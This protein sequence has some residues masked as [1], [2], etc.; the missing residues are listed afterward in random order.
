MIGDILL[1]FKKPF[2]QRLQLVTPRAIETTA[3]N[4]YEGWQESIDK[5]DPRV[6]GLRVLQP[7]EVHFLLCN[8]RENLNFFFGPNLIA[9]GDVTYAGS[10]EKQGVES[11]KIIFSYPHGL[12]YTRYFDAETGELL[13]TI[14]GENGFE[15]VEAESTRVGAIK[16]PKVV[17]TYKDDILQRSVVFD[18]IIVN[19][20]F[21][22]TMFDFPA[23][24]ST[25]G[26]VSVVE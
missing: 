18:E 9:G 19:P 1:Q 3:V 14:S 21:D 20:D 16:F 4:G 2:Y 17:K 10:E 7:M 11:D 23:L 8:A 26:A 6:G 15:M 22:M 5:E 25:K 13:A 24:S 12:T